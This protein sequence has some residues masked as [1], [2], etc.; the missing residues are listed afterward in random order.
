M[1]ES[2]PRFTR[3]SD[4]PESHA[5][6]SEAKADTAC[7]ALLDTVKSTF[8]PF[9]ETFSS[10]GSTLHH[11]SEAVNS[12]ASLQGMPSQLLNTGIAQIPLLDKVPGMPAATIGV[13]HLGTPHAHSHPPSNGFPLPSSG[14]TIGAGCLSVLVGGI[15]AAR[16]LDIGFAPT[17]GGLTPYFDIQ[18]GSSNTFI[19]GMRAA[20]MGIDITRHCNPMGHVGKSGG[21]AE[22]AAEKSEE[23]AQVSGRAK[24]LGR[25]GKAWGI[26]NAAV[27]PAAGAATAASDA[28]HHEDLAAAMTAA[29]TAADLAFMMLSNLMGKDPGIE[30]SM[31]TLLM[32]DPTVLIGGFPLPDAQMMW[33]GAK[34]GIGKKV[35][36][37]LPKWAQK[38]ACE[39]W[40]EPVSAVTGEIENN[41]TDYK[42]D[43]VEPFKWGRHY[44]SGWCERDGMLGYGFR[45]AWQHEL[46]LLRTRAV[47]TDPRGTEYAFGKRADG[48]YSGYC[49]GY[50]IEQVDGRRFIVRHEVEG[51][52]EFERDSATDRS[53]HCVGHIRDGTRSVL[54][55]NEKG[56]LQSITQTDERGRTRR[57]IGFGY[58]G[59]G[60]ILEVVLTDVGGEIHRI[61]HYGYDTSGCLANYRNALDSVSAY[62]YDSQRRIVRLTNANGYAFFYR[63]DHEGRCMES[64]G[65]DGMWHV[66]FEYQPGRTIVTEADGGKWTVLFN[67]VGTITRVV[68]PYGGAAEYVIAPSGRIVEEIDSG[69]RALRWLYDRLDR[70]IGRL[71]RFGNLW[72]GKDDLP[73]L[74][75]PLAHTVSNSMLGLMWGDANDAD[76][77]GGVLLPR[78][79]EHWTWGAAT[80]AA[81]LP[82]E[83]REQRDVAGRVIRHTDMSGHAERFEYDAEDNLLRWFDQDGAATRY[84]RCSWNLLASEE[85]ARGETIRYRYTPRRNIAS[86]TDANGNETVYGYD[87]KN[88]LTSVIRHGQLRETYCYDGGDRLIE[89]HDGTGNW[90]LKFE[91]GNNGLPRE[92]TLAS[93]S[94]HVYE[95]DRF[96]MHTK[97][98]T[99]AHE[100]TRTFD[101]RG[102]LT[103]DKRDGAGVT[104]E[105]DGHRLRRTACFGRFDVMYTPTAQGATS[106]RTLGGRAH[107]IQRGNDG[108]V[109]LQLGNGTQ[110]CYTFDNK[111]RCT[112]RV[113]WRT[114]APAAFRRT[115]YEYS[116]AGELRR[117][118]D[119]EK[120]DTHYQYDGA[121]RL[122]GEVCAGWQTRRYEYDP[123]GNLLSM[124]TCTRMH[125]ADGNR[126]STASHG[127]YRY[128]ER[129]HL[130]EE[131]ARDGRRTTFRYDSMDLL[132]GI[133]WSDRSD[134]WTAEY[135]G[136]CRQIIATTGDRS[137][138]YY[139]S[140]DRLAAQIEPN[141]KLRVFVYVDA[142]SLVPFMF[143]DYPG[144]DAPAASGNEYFVL[145]NQVGM[146]EWIEDGSGDVVWLA[147]EIDPYGTIVVA[148]GN[149][150]EYDVRWPGHWLQ[151]ETGLHVNRFRSYSP[152]LGRY[153]QSD[154][155]G[156]AGGINLYAYTANPVAVVDV[157]G[158]KAHDEGEEATEPSSEDATA[159]GQPQEK[160]LSAQ[161][162]RDEKRARQEA[163]REEIIANL[164]GQIEELEREKKDLASI[165]GNMF[166]AGFVAETNR[167]N[168]II[169]H[170]IP[171]LYEAVNKV[172][173]IR[174]RE[175]EFTST[176]S[177]ETHMEM[178]KRYTL[179]GKK[180]VDEG[181]ISQFP[182]GLDPA[183]DPAGVVSQRDQLQW[184]NGNEKI[185][186][187]KYEKDKDGNY[188]FDAEGNKTYVL[189]ANGRR[190]TNLTYDHQISVAR[191][192][193]HGATVTRPDGTVKKY[194]PGC[195]TDRATRDAFHDDHHNLEAMDRSANAKKGSDFN[196]KVKTGKNYLP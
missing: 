9:K 47:Y 184:V 59:F 90:L 44:C 78:A 138:A 155:L 196:F 139:W 145:C 148:E 195:D 189:D 102:R 46:Q 50:E 83:Q 154:P 169:D 181:T 68:D 95:Y 136:L 28:K 48:I 84:T 56:R 175:N 37:K 186:F 140:E 121:H 159:A 123:A 168:K 172:K 156:L 57:V 67:D 188:V 158:L 7:D 3:A 66:R 87:L 101:S 118:S 142:T 151:R 32:G 143:I 165:T 62:E 106:I 180:W 6:Q 1:S 160:K 81:Q 97:A 8:D 36:P 13:P 127:Q 119:S 111:G 192:Y 146:P 63:Y 183:R 17:C 153:L 132:V 120:G 85:N 171:D 69:G 112:E 167:Y 166:G 74:P 116:G 40:G 60:R 117:V 131:I 21:E 70:N 34:H 4:P 113:T 52:L 103:S 12:L 163:E 45:H 96:G 174:T 53:A 79:V 125:Y 110:V 11:V 94:K 26:G 77:A 176:Y 23:A 92:R 157:L 122:V 194:P 191:M 108:R 104:H 55:W 93:G 51:N 150:V 187:Y 42:T 25:A 5:T 135:D 128:N 64:T 141:G 89:K 82:D 24:L 18:T 73:N 30:P 75:N 29:Q 88:R 190:I 43:G 61:A 170:E 71:D 27:G 58:D 173:G 133:E 129:N 22:S 109:L 185:D 105:Y 137:T 16:V 147:K 39:S 126:L 152:M 178:I 65:Q 91:I 100:I 115:A 31:G 80:A 114:G 162:K 10:K 130:C 177:V 107:C 144:I 76:L 15:P 33:H 98:S 41:F 86:I 99:N 179:E 182:G 134:A 35:R 124:P 2:E 72:P 20:R 49:Q 149:S 54:H 193:T 164:R 14:M 19:G 161:Q 38:L